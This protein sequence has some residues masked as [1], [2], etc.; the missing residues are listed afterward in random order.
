MT[1]TARRWLRIVIS[2]LAL[3]IPALAALPVSA[4]QADVASVSAC[5][6][7]SLTQPFTPWADFDYYKLAP[8]GNFEGTS[9]SWSLSGGA[10]QVSGSESYGVTGS[11]GSSSLA[12]PV[13]AAAQSP[14]TCVNA[15]Y[16]SFRFFVRSDTSGASVSVQAI[17]QDVNGSTV[18][19]PVGSVLAGSS[20]APT[21]P[22]LTGSAIPGAIN[23]G[24]AYVSLRFTAQGGSA[25][26]DDVEVDPFRS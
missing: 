25:Q 5:D 13:G 20:W 19:I 21:P 2:T 18:V 16:P 4:S 9:S 14:S 7:A 11:V 26:I 10:Q 6:G 17:Y 22:M 12:L 8:G 3:S 23:G 15:A 1:V 24:T